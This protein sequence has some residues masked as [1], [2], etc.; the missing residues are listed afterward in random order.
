MGTPSLQYDATLRCSAK[1]KFQS[2]AVSTPDEPAAKKF[3]RFNSP[4]AVLILLHWGYHRMLAAR[5]KPTKV[6]LSLISHQSLMPMMALKSRNA[7]LER[8]KKYPWQTH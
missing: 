2:R 8:R 3:L 5:Y 1:R 7:V 4:K 6:G